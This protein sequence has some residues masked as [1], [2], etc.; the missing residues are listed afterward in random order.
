MSSQSETGHYKNV[1]NL[2]ALKTFAAGLGDNYTPQK[3]TLK[4]SYLET[5]VTEVTTLHEN[6]KNQQN[7]VALAVDNRQ[8]VFENLKP[9]STKVINTMGATNVDAK[10]IEDAKAI[11]A[12][13]QG[14][15]IDKK[16]TT[17]N[18]DTISNSISVSRQSYDSLYE[19]FKSLNNLLQQDGNYSP[20]EENLNIAGLTTKE[21]E[22]L[23]A[24]ETI[25]IE[26][27]NLQNNRIARDKR[28]Y[29][30]EDGL[31]KV[32]QGVKKY[33][34]GKFGVTSPEF[35]QIKA[36]QFKDYSKK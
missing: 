18:P 7:T 31:V 35:A 2:K 4:L 5:L 34:R 14:A 28:F 36:L 30:D 1:A 8:N 23:Q 24:N 16:K 26:N 20:I 13:I 3:D 25:S 27:N 11:N 29:K 12:K 32:A 17:E 33:I 6:V 15:R 19:N 9:L 10:T 22:M 21:N